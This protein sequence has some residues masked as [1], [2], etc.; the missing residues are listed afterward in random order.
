MARK[1]KYMAVGTKQII[2]PP[3]GMMEKITN[4]EFVNDAASTPGPGCPAGSWYKDASGLY[5]LAHADGTVAKAKLVSPSPAGTREGLLT[6]V[7]AA[8]S[9]GTGSLGSKTITLSTAPAQPSGGGAI[10]ALVGGRLVVASGVGI[11]DTYIVTG[12]S[13][14]TASTADLTISVTPALTTALTA[15]SVLHITANPYIST[16]VTPA[17]GLMPLGVTMT[18]VVDGDWYWIQCLGLATVL[19]TDSSGFIVAVAL[20]ALTT[21]GTAGSVEASDSSGIVDGPL[22]GELA[23]RDD[24]NA[25][26]TVTTAYAALAKLSIGYWN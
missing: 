25:V 18:D 19:H 11:G 14:W 9:V 7:V 15:T 23:V 8:A 22:V 3:F 20:H 10:D 12:N 17:N 13:A 4:A 26:V 6:I 24:S 21:S 1:N 5:V 16:I 2:D